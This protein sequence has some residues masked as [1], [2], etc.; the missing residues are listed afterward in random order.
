[1]RGRRVIM[2]SV[3]TGLSALWAWAPVATATPAAP[4]WVPGLAHSD[5]LNGPVLA[6]GSMYGKGG[7]PASGTVYAIA[8]PVQSTLAALKDGERVKTIAIA[9][10]APRAD[11]GFKLRVDPSIPLKEYTEADGTIN[12]SIRGGG[13]DGLAV[14]AVSRR[15]MD[16][17]KPTERWVEPGGGTSA[18]HVPQRL[19]LQLGQAGSAALD[20][21]VTVPLPAADKQM[22]CEEVKAT[23][24]QVV[25]AIGETYPG[26]HA[27]ATFVYT[28]G[29]TST[30]GVG[31]SASG[32]FGSFS[33]G[34]SSTSAQA[35]TLQFPQKTYNSKFIYQSTFQFKKFHGYDPVFCVFDYG[36]EVRTTAF[37]GSV[38]GYDAC[39][40]PSTP[41]PSAVNIVPTHIIKHTSNAVNWSNGVKISAF[42][43]I[44]LSSQ[45]G[46][47]DS[48]EVDFYF[49][50]KG[51]LNGDVES[52]Y[53][54]SARV[55]GT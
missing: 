34:G 15:M 28:N 3:F 31:V 33:Q 18:S 19:K 52:G 55:K 35:T 45:T 1:M 16:K 32:S 43:G 50:A 25:V 17:G 7:R 36:Y 5:H 30:L 44:D 49:T 4:L 14:W 47:S 29:Q 8:W 51:N 10:A 11:G 39:C 40:A 53:P 9:Q 48:A 41:Y 37:S 24:N 6:E 27:K 38:L 42:I 46:Y 21:N 54:N 12:L 2:T 13:A 23:Y 20:G 26:P 22:G